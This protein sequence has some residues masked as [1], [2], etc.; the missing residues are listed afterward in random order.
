MALLPG[1][2]A[3]DAGNNAV[4]TPTSEVQTVTITGSSG[5]FTLTFNGNTTAA[6]PL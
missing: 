4:V 1:S 2:P 3:I 5:A 6:I